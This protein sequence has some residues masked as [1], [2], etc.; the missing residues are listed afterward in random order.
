MEVYEDTSLR[1][2]IH[3]HAKRRAQNEQHAE[4]AVQESW[5]AISCLDNT[6]DTDACKQVA[7]RV[8]YHDYWN[9]NKEK[10]LGEH[11]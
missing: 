5:L 2:H 8:I 1:E 6:V 10:L 9:R 4:E 3:T 7:E 11:P